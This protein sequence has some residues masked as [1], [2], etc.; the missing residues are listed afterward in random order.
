MI[1]NV[2]VIES[3]NSRF[4]CHLDIMAFTEEQ[5]RSRMMERG[6]ADEDFFVC[7]FE[8]WGIDT[9]MSLQ[10]AY[11]L[12][13]CI[14]ELY[15]GDEFIVKY[16]LKQHKSPNTIISHYYR[17]VSK[18]EVAVMKKILSGVESDRLVQ[19]FFD[20]NSWIGMFQEYVEQGYI[21]N[22]PKGFYMEG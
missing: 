2:R 6:I 13:R 19:L 18:D 21:L 8:D 14:L 11:R 3:G 22:T 15:D 16:L 5:C 12:K 20:C 17:F 4:L 1:A 9:I 7:G 10:D